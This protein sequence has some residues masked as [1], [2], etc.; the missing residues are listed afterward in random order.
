MTVDQV[1]TLKRGDRVRVDIPVSGGVFD[2][3]SGEEQEL[4]LPAGSVAMVGGPRFIGGN[5]G[6]GIDLVFDNGIVN[7]FDEGDNPK[8]PFE[9]TK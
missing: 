7:T 8:F 6:W 9:R 4:T 2:P 5:Q 1:R 3:Y